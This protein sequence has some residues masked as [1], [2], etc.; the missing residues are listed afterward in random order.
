MSDYS[1]DKQN[2]YG[3]SK[4]TKQNENLRKSIA[5][6]RDSKE[7]G[8]EDINQMKLNNEKLATLKGKTNEI[9]EKSDQSKTILGK[10]NS[11]WRRL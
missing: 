6:L 5:L 4:I 8:S 10:M 7:I 9:V 2:D 3:K 11:F 1:Q